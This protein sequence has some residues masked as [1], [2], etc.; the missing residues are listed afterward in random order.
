M[1]HAMRGEKE[2]PVVD[3]AELA[4]SSSTNS[5]PSLFG[6]TKKLDRRVM[7]DYCKY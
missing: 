3:P 5:V 6:E 2:P 7:T 1:W 4:R